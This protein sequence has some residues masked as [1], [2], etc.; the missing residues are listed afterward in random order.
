MWKPVD[1]GSL[2][3]SLEKILVIVKV[4]GVLEA[5]ENEIDAERDQ[6][7]R[8]PSRRP[9]TCTAI[10]LILLVHLLFLSCM[11]NDIVKQV[12]IVIR[13]LDT[14]QY[15]DGSQWRDE[16][17]Y[18]TVTPDVDGTWSYANAN[19]IGNFMFSSRAVDQSGN[20]EKPPALM[21]FQV[22]N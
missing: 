19:L 7:R 4:S 13:D 16:W 20:V 21:R 9:G 5:N 12:R 18:F 22:E 1:E 10:T 2:E 14:Q 11:P 8:Q 15:Y 3:R 17:T 6:D